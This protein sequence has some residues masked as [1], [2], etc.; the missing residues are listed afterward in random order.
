MIAFRLTKVVEVIRLWDFF[1]EGFKSIATKSKQSVDL[2]IA[3]KTVLDLV[4][5]TESAW[6]GV[7]YDSDRQPIAFAVAQECT[8]MFDR[9]RRF[10]VRWFYHSSDNFLATKTLMTAFETW[11]REKGI[12]SYAVTTKRDSGAAIRCFQSEKFGFAKSFLTFEKFL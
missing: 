9:D 12:V 2:V 1:E 6:I 3:K 4:V 11:A 10:L 7:S 5:D 8:P